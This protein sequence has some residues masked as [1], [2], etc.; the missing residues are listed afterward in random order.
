MFV[1]VTSSWR[2]LRHLLHILCLIEKSP[3]TFLKCR[4]DFKQWVGKIYASY[5]DVGVAKGSIKW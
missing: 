2:P 4:C 5:I 3:H 1:Q